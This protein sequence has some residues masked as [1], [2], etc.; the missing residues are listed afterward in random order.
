MVG[1]EGWK[2]VLAD[3]VVRGHRRAWYHS[4]IRGSAAGLPEFGSVYVEM[5][6]EFG[7]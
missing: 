1:N 2:D 7:L 3:K 4:G 5:L 6:L